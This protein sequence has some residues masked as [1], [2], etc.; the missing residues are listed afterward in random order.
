MLKN[1]WAYNQGGLIFQ[2]IRYYDLGMDLVN[3]TIGPLPTAV[4]KRH[5]PESPS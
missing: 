5:R 2:L 4:I 1:T 3:Y